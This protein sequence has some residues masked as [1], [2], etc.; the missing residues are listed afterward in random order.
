[1][2]LKRMTARFQS[3]DP[4]K[5]VGE[6]YPNEKIADAALFNLQEN[7]FVGFAGLKKPAPILALLEEGEAFNAYVAANSERNAIFLFFKDKAL[8]NGQPIPLTPELL[9]AL[10]K[11]FRMIKSFGGVL[12]PDGSHTIDLLS[13]EV[14]PHYGVNLLL[15]WREG[16]KEPLLTTPKS[17]VDSFGR[18]SFRAKAAYQVLATR[19]DIRPEENGNPFNRQFYLLEN[20]KQIFYSADVSHNVSK[21]FCTHYP[22][23]TCIVYDLKDGLHIERTIALLDQ[24]EGLPDAT[25]VQ[26]VRLVSPTERHLQIVFTGTFGFS[27]PGC[28]EVDVIYQTVIHQS[29]ALFNE[30]NELVALSPNYYPCYFNKS[31]RFVSLISNQGFADSFSND[32]TAFL[33]HGDVAHPE[34]LAHLNNAFKMKGASFFALN[35]TFV[36]SPEKPFEAATFTGMMDGEKLPEGSVEETL[37]QEIAKLQESFPSVDSISAQIA[38][39]DQELKAYSSYFQI[40]SGNPLTDAMM[41]ANIP[42]QTR[43][44]S[45][46]SRA[47]AQTQ[48]GYREIGFR[49]V[50]DL[51]AA[52][53][54]LVSSGKKALASELLGNWIKNVYK[55]GY[56]NHNFFEVGKEPGM[57]SDDSLWLLEAVKTYVEATGDVSYLEKSFPMADGGERPLKDTLEAILTYSTKI[58][59]GKHGLPLLDRADWN[60]CL[61]IDVDCLDGPTKEKLY[62]QQLL[63]K[64]ETYGAPLENDLSESVMNAFLLVCALNDAIALSELEKDQ[65]K[66]A[67]YE[68][69]KADEVKA[70]RSSCFINGYYA[71]VLINR[72]NPKNG[73]RYVGAPGDGLSSVKSLQNGSL[74]LNSFSWSLLS[75]VASEEEIASMLSLADTYLKTPSGYKL[76]SEEDLTLTGAKEAATSHYFPGDRENGGV[77]KHATMMFARALLSSAKGAYSLPLRKKMVEDAYFM[78]HLVYPYHC[79][80]NPYRY[81]GNPRFCTQYNNPLTEENIG[82]ILSGT[83]TW[84]TLSLWEA[85]GLKKTPEGLVFEPILEKGQG[86]YSYTYRFEKSMYQVQVSKKKN[87]YAFEVSSLSV[88]GVSYDPKSPIPFLDDGKS[89]QVAIVLA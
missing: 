51:Y 89:H 50:Q 15:G 80:E 24:K 33:G 41:N 70:I 27:N 66:K 39:Q 28:Q 52:I 65:T 31:P 64:N 46:V 16:F 20:G 57:C 6:A 34:G 3:V 63:A 73:I 68:S 81:K 23:K 83:A 21:A 4:F 26:S 48:K 53:P 11:A 77:F 19:W 14:G 55:M 60:D 35:K 9:K 54:Y 18:G 10:R 17:V 5:V 76:C 37:A 30:R 82:P 49:E 71:R 88:D 86:D 85:A 56:A 74:Y 8:K 79:F 36:V 43:Y 62:A 87:H 13:P 29:E 47:F 32:S 67:L 12:N 44:Q 22:S 1:M 59:I 61:K 72:E 25:E 42:F 40:A 7:I 58:S 75:R 84:L 38:Q 69:Y 45:F 78:L 2:V